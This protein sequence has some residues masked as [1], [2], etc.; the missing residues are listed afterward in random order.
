[1]THPITDPAA[2]LRWLVDRAHVSDLLVEFA[3]ALDVRD[4]DA[5]AATYT[6]DAVLE[7]G[8]LARLEGRAAIRAATA[9]ERGLGGYAGTW[10]GS[11][12]HAVTV[13]GDTA[14]SRSYL[15]GVH[16]LGGGSAHHADG[17]GWYDCALRRTADVDLAGGWRFTRVRITEVWHAGEPLPHVAPR[18]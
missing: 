2:A 10:H 3:R 8:D 17:A 4:W 5:Y 14:T 7:I 16:L 9:S 15:L 6:E 13:D 1:M 12:N 11:S 18:P